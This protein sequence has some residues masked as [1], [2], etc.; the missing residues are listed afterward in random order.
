MKIALEE[1]VAVRPFFAPRS[2]FSSTAPH[3]LILARLSPAGIELTIKQ[4]IAIGDF[5][6]YRKSLI[7]G[8]KVRTSKA[9]ARERDPSKAAHLCRYNNLA[10][11]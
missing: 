9:A 1:F 3:Y 6:A 10:Q 5:S 8:N 2:G 7:K 11:I 4:K